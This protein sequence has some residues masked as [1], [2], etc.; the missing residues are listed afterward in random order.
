MVQARR[1]FWAPVSYEIRVSQFFTLLIFEAE[2]G[3]TLRDGFGIGHVHGQAHISSGKFRV[4]DQ[5]GRDCHNCTIRQ[6]ATPI[7][8][9]Q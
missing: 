9:T 5:T 8:R 4:G 6:F 3:L 2:C 1:R 7:V